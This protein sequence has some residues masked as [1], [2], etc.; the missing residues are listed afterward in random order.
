MRVDGAIVGVLGL[1]GLLLAC[2]AD[3]RILEIPTEQP[4]AAA[5]VI[6]IERSGDV[7]I[8]QRTLT[9]KEARQPPPTP[10]PAP[11]WTPAPTATSTVTPTRTATATGTATRTPSPTRTGT[12]TP[13]PP[14]LVGAIE[15]LDKIDRKRAR[16]TGPAELIQEFDGPNRTRV[17]LFGSQARE[18]VIIDGQVFVRD[19][20]Y[21]R[22]S[23]DHPFHLAERLDLRVNAFSGDR[24]AREL[25]RARERAGECRDWDVLDARADEPIRVCIGLNDGLPYRV[26]YPGDEVIEFYDFGAPIRVPD[27]VPIKP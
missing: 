13:R 27:P 16:L 24:N 12:P 15:R 5:K 18:A 6:V 23:I 8:Q 3:P 20:S 4:P 10:T 9:E 19:G 7:A 21:W 22:E 25:P 2:T 17:L 1:T 14:D 26:T 11:A